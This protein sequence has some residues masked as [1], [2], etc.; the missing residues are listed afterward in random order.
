MMS[1]QTLNHKILRINDTSLLFI[2]IFLVAHQTRVA[3]SQTVF[4]CSIDLDLCT[5]NPL[6]SLSGILKLIRDTLIDSVAVTD[7][8]SIC[9]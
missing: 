1:R 3:T 4:S 6:Y 2:L 5:G 9:K 7:V 8:T